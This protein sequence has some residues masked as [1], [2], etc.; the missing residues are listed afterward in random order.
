MTEKIKSFLNNM[1]L[2]WKFFLSFLIVTVVCVL[3]LGIYSYQHTKKL[4]LEESFQN[5]DD[6]LA[7]VNANLNML[8]Q[9]YTNASSLVFMEQQL[10]NL[11][12]TDFSDYHYEDLYWYLKEFFGMM[13][14]INDDVQTFSIYTTNDTIAADHY[15]IYKVTEETAEEDWYQQAVAAK[16]YPIFLRGGIDDEGNNVF[17]LVRLLDYYRYDGLHNVLRMEIREDR[18]YNTISEVSD[19]DVMMIL[20]QED[21]I[22]TSTDWVTLGTPV[23]ELLPEFGEDGSGPFVEYGGKEMLLRIMTTD[24]GWKVVSLVD[25]SAIEEN[26]GSTARYIIVFTVLAVA[27]AAVLAVAFSMLFS[28]RLLILNRAAERMKEG[29]F[30]ETIED[31]GQ[32]EIGR[33][34]ETF[35]EMSSMVNHLIRDIYEKEMIRKTA[36]LNLLQEQVNPHFLYNALSS[37]N[38]LAVRKGNHQISQMVQHLADFY[39]ISLNKGKSILTV[40]EE[41]NLLNHY[42]EIQK[43]R[44]ADSVEVTYDLDENLMECRVIKLILQPVVEN[45]IHHAMRAENELLHIHI[46]LKRVSGNAAGTEDMMFTI[47]DDGMGMDEETVRELNSEMQSVVR[48]F[49]LKNIFIRIN[50]QY[51]QGYGVQVY[52]QNGE[53]TRI[54]MR[55]PVLFE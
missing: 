50:M 2:R 47:T 7:Q 23:R 16:G 3:S 26:V 33:L 6:E 44:F 8:M 29:V 21:V 30:G 20:D 1:S 38:S 11:I 48:G 27:L 5:M 13:L 4:L 19:G 42:L 45:A 35:S 31:M 46:E 17:Y 15:Y 39:R 53:G 43:V 34:A 54:E 52:S 28:R 9:E 10:Q 49:G 36:E 37:I 32:D 14:A 22:I 18:V 24:C 40:Q 51:G 55:L 41:V 12:S 25:V